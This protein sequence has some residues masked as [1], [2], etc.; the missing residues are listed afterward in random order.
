MKLLFQNFY[1][2]RKKKCVCCDIANRVDYR[3]LLEGEF[4]I[5]GD[6]EVCQGC[7]EAFRDLVAQD[8]VVQEFDFRN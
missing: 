4:G 7:A 2:S 1:K 6:L 5:V 3:L 8:K